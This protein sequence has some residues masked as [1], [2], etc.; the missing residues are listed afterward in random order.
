M[1]GESQR[2][3]I[4]HKKKTAFVNENVYC[5]LW[6]KHIL[7]IAGHNRLL[8]FECDAGECDQGTSVATYQMKSEPHQTNPH[9]DEVSSDK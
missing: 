1:K 3:T 9:I 4:L 8:V 5:M 7:E 2:T 6:N